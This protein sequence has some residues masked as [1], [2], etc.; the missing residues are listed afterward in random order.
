MLSVKLPPVTKIYKDISRG[1]HYEWLLARS[2]KGTTFSPCSLL[3]LPSACVINVYIYCVASFNQHL[4]LHAFISYKTR[5]R[6]C[7]IKHSKC[8][9]HDFTG[10]L[11]SYWM[12]MH[13]LQRTIER[14]WHIYRIYLV[15]YE[16]I[17]VQYTVEHL[18]ILGANMLES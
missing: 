5:L 14:G 4:M 11:I 16:N 18:K 15:I 8:I 13:M 17:R 9:Q 12:T 2:R 7:H 6:R 10:A 1:S 3:W